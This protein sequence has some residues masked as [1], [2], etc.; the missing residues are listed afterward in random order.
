MTESEKFTKIT[1]EALER[2]NTVNDLQCMLGYI[3]PDSKLPLPPNFLNTRHWA[4]VFYNSFVR[5]KIPKI[6]LNFVYPA[7]SD[8]D[9]SQNEKIL[10]DLR[11]FFKP[12]L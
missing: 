11:F 12:Y 8:T 5:Q 6:K 10:T 7:L 4:I 1:T 9:R 2:C 3:R